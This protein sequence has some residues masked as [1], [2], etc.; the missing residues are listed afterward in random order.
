M[1]EYW[2]RAALRAAKDAA[3]LLRIETRIAWAFALLLFPFVWLW[4]LFQTPAVF[5]QEQNDA[6][7]QLRGEISKIQE[8]MKPRIAFGVVKDMRGNPG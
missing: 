2:W 7:A 1:A 8:Q 6:I 4:K 5:E 3:E